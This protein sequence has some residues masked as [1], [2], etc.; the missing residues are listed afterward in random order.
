MS[1]AL[2]IQIILA[3]PSIIKL[4]IELFKLI[5]GV[6][7]PEVKNA[8]SDR[9]AAWAAG[10]KAKG[11]VDLKDSALLHELFKDVKQYKGSV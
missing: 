7:D 10:I 3:I 1:V 5:N 11:A 8:F 6:S 9:F 2:I 4:V